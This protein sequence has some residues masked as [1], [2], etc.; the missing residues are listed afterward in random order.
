MKATLEA[1]ESERNALDLKYQELWQEA[2]GLR[3]LISVEKAKARVGELNAALADYTDEQ[4]E[5]AKD[6]IAAFEADPMNVEINSIVDKI[7]AGIGKKAI[8]DAKVA[9]Q[10]AA[11][12]QEKDNANFDIFEPVYEANEKSEEISIF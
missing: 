4:K 2:E 5:Y 6:A 8:E 9:E 12:Q 7:L 11:A 10:N 3:V 1:V